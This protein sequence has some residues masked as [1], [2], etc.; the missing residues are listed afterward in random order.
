MTKKRVLIIDDSAFMRKMLT[1]LIQQDPELDVIG[2]ARNGEEGVKKTLNLQPD[3]VTLD[4]EMPVLDGLSALRQIMEQRPTPVVML[5]SLTSDGAD[6]TIKALQLG[7]VDFI[8][9]PSGSI[10]LDIDQ[11]AT[12]IRKKVK[13]AITANFNRYD[14]QKVN[15]IEVDV[16]DVQGK[17]PSFSYDE[18]IVAI[19]VSTGGPKALEQLLTEIP[20][21]FKASLL[22]VQH[23]PEKFTKSLANRLNRLSPIHVKE[24]TNGEIV[25]PGTAYIAPGNYHLT[26]RKIGRSLALSTEQNEPVRG[27]RPSVDVLFESLSTV[28]AINK[29]AVVLTGMGSD[30]TEGAKR[31]KAQGQTYLIAESQ[32]TA[33]IYGMPKA[34]IEKV[35]VNLIVPI[36]RVAQSLVDVVN[37]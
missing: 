6:S 8:N 1:D 32:Q 33:L 11:I 18:T 25:K 34:V 7:A 4:V 5:S 23:M 17:L 26:I 15:P 35:G 16:R 3:V 21:D 14:V 24:A 12:D 9:K 30:G 29:V 10:S 36:D 31:L 28:D 37:N 22:I 2:T 19:G 20:K 13:Q 27:H